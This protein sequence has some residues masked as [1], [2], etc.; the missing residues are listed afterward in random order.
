MG[1]EHRTA[2]A[3][4]V[5]IVED[6]DDDDG[7]F[8]SGRFSATW[9]DQA[10]GEHLQ[11]PQSVPADEAIAWG[12]SLADVLIVR[13]DET[14]M[15]SAGIHQPHD[16]VLSAWPPAGGLP[17]RRRAPSAAYL[18]RTGAE[19]PIPWDSNI[20]VRLGGRS[21]GS[22]AGRF[23]DVVA[24]DSE[25]DVTGIDSVEGDDHWMIAVSL[26]VVARTATAAD[27]RAEMVARRALSRSL[28]ATSEASGVSWVLSCRGSQPGS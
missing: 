1:R 5:F 3:G 26:S 13:V 27:D 6:Y 2:R 25:V 23:V 19:P 7:T 9:E 21:A 4:V 15:Y 12:R 11:G 24:A 10:T 18:D 14:D 16:C 28:E 8:L 17:S 22:V 20:T